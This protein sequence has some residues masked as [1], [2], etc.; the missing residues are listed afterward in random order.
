[1]FMTLWRL[2]SPVWSVRRP[3]CSQHSPRHPP[4]CSLIAVE[5]HGRK[6]GRKE[7]KKEEREGGS[8]YETLCHVVHQMVHHRYPAS[9]KSPNISHMARH[10]NTAIQ[11][12]NFIA[13]WLKKL[14]HLSCQTHRPLSWFRHRSPL[15]QVWSIPTGIINTEIDVVLS[16]L[17]RMCEWTEMNQAVDSKN[18]KLFGEWVREGVLSPSFRKS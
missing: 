4:T 1:M 12:I 13:E 11:A 9:I 6:E 18:L 7:G 15:L 8:V 3:V 16:I 14:T 5:N 2:F 17:M 10:H